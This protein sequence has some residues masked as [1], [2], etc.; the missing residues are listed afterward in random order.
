MTSPTFLVEIKYIMY[1]NLPKSRT[2][3]LLI[4]SKKFFTGIP[5]Q[6]G[7][8]E[9]RYTYMGGKTGL[10]MGC[11]RNNVKRYNKKHPNKT[12]NIRHRSYLKNREKANTRSK[13]W[14]AKNPEKRK[15]IR[16]KSAL[17][18]REKKLKYARDRMKTLRQDPNFRLSKNMSKAVWAWL[19]GS[20]AFRHWEEFVNFTIDELKVHLE[21]QFKDGM[22]WENYGSYWHIDHIKPLVACTSFQEAWALLNLQPLTQ[23][24]N[25]SKGSLYKGKRR[26]RSDPEP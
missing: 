5:C 26:Y 3:A 14:A 18:H 11:N 15:L 2:E 6:N 17:K 24:E 25:S 7:H 19:K 1:E 21:S 23:L 9:P 22:T 10:C 16:V 4:K 20:K 12:K 13:I 8:I